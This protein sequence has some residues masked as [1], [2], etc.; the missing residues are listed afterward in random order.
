MQKVEL[1]QK[2]FVPCTIRSSGEENTV[3][4][5][6]EDDM[7]RFFENHREV[8]SSDVDG[9]LTRLFVRKPKEERTKSDD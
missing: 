6:D 1:I 5:M 3:N 8:F 2:G 7:K 9:V 4:P